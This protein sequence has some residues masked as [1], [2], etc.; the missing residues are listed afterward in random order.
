MSLGGVG[1][2]DDPGAA[3]EALEAYFLRRVLSEVRPD[4]AAGIDGGFAGSTFHEMLDEALADAMAKAGGLG[5]APMIAADMGAA[6]PVRTAFT[7]AAGYP[8]ASPLSVRPVPGSPT[9]PFGER[10]DPIDGSTNFH[11]GLDLAAATGTPVAVA[12]PGVVVRAESSGSYGNM[13]VVDHGGGLETRYAHL[14]GYSVKVGDR[15]DAGDVVGQ[16]GA[17]GRVTGPHLHFEV[18]RDGKPVDPRGELPALK[19]SK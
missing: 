8:V 9:S 14:S 17:T 15:L 5:L 11:T 7:P 12:G 18:R 16:A 13:V 6:R 19:V 10:A 1:K 4:E 2:P 3:A